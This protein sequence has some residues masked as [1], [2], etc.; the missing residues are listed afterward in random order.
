MADRDVNKQPHTYSWSPT[1][2]L[3]SE[4][5]AIGSNPGRI[6]PWDSLL[7]ASKGTAEARYA[8]EGLA[9]MVLAAEYRTLLPDEKLIAD[10]LARSRQT[11]ESRRSPIRTTERR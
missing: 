1:R 4:P 6:R 5:P 11:L 9:N 3:T 10:E 2:V 7:C 8:L